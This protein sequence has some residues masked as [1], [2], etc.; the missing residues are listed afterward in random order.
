MLKIIVFGNEKGGS[1]KTTVAMHLMVY[2]IQKKNKV[3]ILDLD[4][5]Q[6]SFLDYIKNRAK[7]IN[8]N[9][10][11]LTMSETYEILSSTDD[12]RKI[13]QNEDYTAL[14]KAVDN[15]KKKKCDYLLIDCPGAHT[16]FTRRAHEIA[17]LLITP[18][19]DSFIDFK[20]LADFEIESQ[21]ILHSSVYSELIWSVR[22]KRLAQNLPNLHWKV[23]RNR[24]SQLNS[25]NQNRM[26]RALQQFSKRSGFKIVPGFSERMI[27]RELF[28][29][30]L[31]L[32]DLKVIPDWELSL[33]HVA[34]NNEMRNFVNALKL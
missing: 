17:N 10:V 1:G 21:S 4:I 6:L 32:L 28:P 8:K 31:T 3:G 15:F 7:F 13:A 25:K 20:L 34:A 24:V 26:S 19:N 18:L 22:K 9:G 30:G 23:L 16:N 5:R 11:N 14:N 29:L 27:Y 12:S 33:S 2:L